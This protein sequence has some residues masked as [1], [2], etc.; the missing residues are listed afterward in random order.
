MTRKSHRTRFWRILTPTLLLAPSLTQ[1]ALASPP[2][3]ATRVPPV[4]VITT[5][6]VPT[7][8]PALLPF[9]QELDQ[10]NL[11]LVLDWLHS[12]LQHETNLQNLGERLTQRQAE[13]V[14]SLPAAWGPVDYEAWIVRALQ[15]DAQQEA[16][17]RHLLH[18]S[19]DYLNLKPA[20]Q[21]LSLWEVQPP[22]PS[23][24]SIHASDFKRVQGFPPEMQDLGPETPHTIPDLQHYN[25]QRLGQVALE[26]TL[27]EHWPLYLFDCDGSQALSYLQAQG[28]DQ[29]YQLNAF[30]SRWG[31]EVYLARHSGPQAEAQTA[32]VYAGIYGDWMETHLLYMLRTSLLHTGKKPDQ[33]LQNRQIQRLHLRPSSSA[34]PQTTRQHYLDAYRHDLQSLKDPQA[35]RHLLVLGYYGLIGR[36]IQRQYQTQHVGSASVPLGQRQT[37]Q[38]LLSESFRWRDQQGQ[39][40]QVLNLGAN[41]SLY[42]DMTRELV[43]IALEEDWHEIVF[44]GSAGAI[45]SDF[46]IYS[47]VVPG[48]FRNLQGASIQT[49]NYLSYASAGNPQRPYLSYATV[50]QGVASPVAETQALISRLH[51]EGVATVDVEV[52]EIAQMMQAY[53]Q[54]HFSAVLL[55]TDYPGAFLQAQAPSQHHLD[56]VDY[57]RKYQ[58]LPLL[59]QLIQNRY[60]LQEVLPYAQVP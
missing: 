23:A 46:P 25:R 14:S 41:H 37:G 38:A 26:H 44:A 20:R 57:G 2:S 21:I 51:S 36:E 58:Y 34:P 29:F 32:L 8:D 52:A 3:L 4:K 30:Y 54:A 9:K 24:Q 33:V 16:P 39:S 13:I 45:R 11:K 48:S 55:V 35:Q 42:G 18:H 5:A 12:D 7:P 10:A 40:W 28:Y 1:A 6:S 31:K 59:W 17:L 49:P 53:P 56:R 50:H 19:L 43:R 22:E 47:L 15:P 27:R 60:R